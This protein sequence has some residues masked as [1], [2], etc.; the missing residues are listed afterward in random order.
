LLAGC[1]ALLLR[2]PVDRWALAAALLLYTALLWRWPQAW[3]LV[4]P[5]LVPVL[6]L[7]PRSGWIYWECVDFFLAVTLAA[8]L[9]HGRAMGHRARLAPAALLLML[10]L[11]LAAG[12][13][14]LR[15]L[16][17]PAPLDANA[18]VGYFSPYNS[19]RVAKGLLWALLLLTLLR[20]SLPDR[21]AFARLLLP[22]F[23]AGFVGVVLAVLWER[24]IFSGLLNFTNEFRVTATFS[25]MHTG[26]GH[27][28][29]YL[30]L[31]LPLVLAAVFVWR[32]LRAYLFGLL[33]LPLGAYALL[34]T[35][36]RAG[37]LALGVSLALLCIGLLIAFLRG[38]SG[39]VTL[40]LVGLGSLVTLVI[41][42][43]LSIAKAPYLHERFSQ[44]ERD[45]GI[46]AEHWAA[47]LRMMD[48]DWTT[49]LFGMGLGRFPQAYLFAH[50]RDNLLG[51]FWFGEEQGNS[52]LRLGAGDSLYFE[53][54]VE[55]RKS[56]V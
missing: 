50:H 7:V 17:P 20:R 45:F 18:F 30:A 41:A 16:L 46:R 26:G 19:L 34:V 54:L 24:Q 48:P 3:L 10:L 1:A 8:S 29:G 25:T 4:I 31:V 14:M 47:G 38:R 56:V 51:T 42:V 13:A 39:G 36:S 33:L 15:G 9:W 27:I 12:I 28:E 6:D 37:V 5:A 2:Y 32:G 55:D 44:V 53:Q 49:Q 43:G 52:Y 21:E 11:A 22:G 23:A 40:R 35:F